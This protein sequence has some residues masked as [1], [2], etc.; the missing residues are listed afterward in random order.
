MAKDADVDIQPI[1]RAD[2]VPAKVFRSRSMNTPPALHVHGA[3]VVLLL[4]C[5][6]VWQP[7]VPDVNIVTSLGRLYS[8]NKCENGA[9]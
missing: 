4:S 2:F 3:D 8:V 7:E 9:P 1:A 5:N 6:P